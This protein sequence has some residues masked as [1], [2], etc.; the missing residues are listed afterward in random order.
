[1][2]VAKPTCLLRA[3]LRTRDRRPPLRQVHTWSTCQWIEEQ[4]TT[5]RA[6]GPQADR[7]AVRGAQGQMREANAGEVGGIGGLDVAPMTDIR[8]HHLLGCRLEQGTQRVTLPCELLDALLQLVD[9]ASVRGQC[10]RTYVSGLGAADQTLHERTSL[11]HRQAQGREG[12]DL[13]D[14][15]HRDRVVLA[16]PVRTTMRDDQPGHLAVPQSTHRDTST[17]R[18]LTN[19]HDQNLN[20]YLGVQVNPP[21]SA[22]ASRG[23]GKRRHRR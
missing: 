22:M 3:A 8:P 12:A 10:R 13:L 9:G 15:S 11:L 23:R 21:A 6:Q 19:L 20:P 16:V 5:F 14:Q 7:P 1:M 17:P 4:H 18:Q 2:V